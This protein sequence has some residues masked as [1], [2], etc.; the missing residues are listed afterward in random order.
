MKLGLKEKNDCEAIYQLT[1]I[2]LDVVPDVYGG[3]F[4][5]PANRS[6]IPKS[7]S[8]V[9]LIILFLCMQSNAKFAL[10]VEPQN[11]ALQSRAQQVKELRDKDQPTV[12]TKLTCSRTYSLLCVVVSSSQSN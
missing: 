1:T 12:S 2:I 5:V 3:G 7:S 4:C 9:C 11:I 6:E 8:I 10:T